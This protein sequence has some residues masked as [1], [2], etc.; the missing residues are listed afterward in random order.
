MPVQRK[1]ISKARFETF[2][3]ICSVEDPAMLVHVDRAFMCELGYAASPLWEQPDTGILSAPCEVHFAVTNRCNFRCKGCY[4]NG[5]DPDPGELSLDDFRRAV[6]LFAGMGV[7]HMA[8]GGGEAFEREDFLEIARYVRSRGIVPNLTTNGFHITPEIARE[9]AVFGQVNVSI[10]GIGE[11]YREIRGVDGFSAASA[12]LRHL[13][14]AGVQ[15]GIN[16]TVSRLN[17]DSLEEIAGLA[18]Q[19]G[20]HD[21]ELLRFKPYGRGMRG[22]GAMRLTDEQHRQVFDRFAGLSRNYGIPV[23]IDCSFLPM[24]CYHRPDRE[25]MEQLSVGGCDAGNSLLGVRSDGTF[26]GCSFCANEESAFGLPFLW[27][28]SD[29]LRQCR[30]RIERLGEPCNRC[31][32][33]DIC[34]GGCRAVAAFITGNPDAPDPECPF[35]VERGL[36]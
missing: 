31:S 20:L 11:Q 33:I 36:T 28:A 10:D 30:T 5:G 16:C 17:F 32:Y 1:Q 2:G 4:M 34:K 23:R 27:S 18:R 29:H 12:A 8:L 9:C 7:F 35:V 14:D 24:A 3:G 13:R 21:V 26:S 25:V 15:T 22:Y 6:D 19:Y